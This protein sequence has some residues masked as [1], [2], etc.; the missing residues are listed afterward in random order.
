MTHCCTGLGTKNLKE[1]FDFDY[2]HTEKGVKIHVMPK[3][4]SKV[5]SF[6]KF[7]EAYNDYCDFECC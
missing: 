7:V 2:E 6:K 5:E 3:D 4:Q 1:K